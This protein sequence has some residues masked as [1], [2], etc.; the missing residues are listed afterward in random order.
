MSAGIAE[1]SGLV[2]AGVAAAGLSACTTTKTQTAASTARPDAAPLFGFRV[3]SRLSP[4]SADEL[5]VIAS[6][7]SRNHR[8]E[9]IVLIGPGGRIVRALATRKDRQTAR[10]SRVVGRPGGAVGIGT[11]GIGFG[12]GAPV[13]LDSFLDSI[14]LS[15]RS[16]WRYRTVATL[17]RPAKTGVRSPWKVRVKLT[18]RKDREIHIVRSLYQTLDPTMTP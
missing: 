14:F 16:G 7:R 13:N 5:I 10:G 2:L 8:I 11:G 1:K 15:E 12:I 6:H 9:R 4:A 3:A 17:R 18:D